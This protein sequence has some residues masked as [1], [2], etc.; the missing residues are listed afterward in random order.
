MCA[1]M[2]FGGQPEA[3]VMFVW[4]RLRALSVETLAQKAPLQLC[5][6]EYGRAAA[7]LRVFRH[8][9]RSAALSDPRAQVP[10]G[11]ALKCY[12]SSYSI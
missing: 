7:D 12:H 6:P 2:F 4:R 5:P 3:D 11:N 1:R 10:K 9:A 8:D